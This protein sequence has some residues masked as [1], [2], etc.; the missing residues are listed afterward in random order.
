MAHRGASQTGDRVSRSRDA[1]SGG[2]AEPLKAEE[3]PVLLRVA[4]KGVTEEASLAA[5]GTGDKALVALELA[6]VLV[7]KQVGTGVMDDA[8]LRIAADGLTVEVAKVVGPQH[9]IAGGA[10]ELALEGAAGH[11]VA[12]LGPSKEGHAE[13]A[14]AVALAD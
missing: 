13:A 7:G 12:L 9:P 5:A 8:V 2:I 10:A 4:L 11:R 1:R 6:A 3:L 14:V